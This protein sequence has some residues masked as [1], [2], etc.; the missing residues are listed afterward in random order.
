MVTGLEKLF[1]SKEDDRPRI[2]M[3]FPPLEPRDQFRKT[4]YLASFPQLTGSVDVF[5]GG[6]KEHRELLKVYEGSD[7]W[8][9]ALTPS[10]LMMVPA[11]CHNVYPRFAGP[12]AEPVVVE[13]KAWC[14][15]HEPELDPMR[16]VCFRIHEEVYIG[17]AEGAVEHREQWMTN[18]VEIFTEL[19]VQVTTDVAN[20][21]FFGRAG[22]IM[23]SG[24]K[25]E[26][27]KF[28]VLTNIYDDRQTA[29]ASGNAHRTHFGENFDI[30]L[31]DGSLALRT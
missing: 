10:G 26:A 1:V 9:D 30:A 14:F 5:T 22:R 6:D 15:R 25:S 18:L 16:M 3:Y 28:E 23:A 13:T 29:V 2:R 19:G 27:L 17:T 11:T 20:D 12:L 21:P 4:D 31:P 8:A 24:Q 7:E